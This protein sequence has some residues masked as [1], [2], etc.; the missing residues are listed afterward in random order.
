MLLLCFVEQRRSK[1][2]VSF[3][4][5]SY[6]MRWWRV[7]ATCRIYRGRHHLRACPIVWQLNSMTHSTAQENCTQSRWKHWNVYIVNYDYHPSTFRGPFVNKLLKLKKLAEMKRDENVW[8]EEIMQT[9][10]NPAG[11]STL[12]STNRSPREIHSKTICRRDTQQED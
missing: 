1:V 12:L 11:L 6:G 5:C 4:S 10:L 3:S 2:S 9:W 7:H 8:L